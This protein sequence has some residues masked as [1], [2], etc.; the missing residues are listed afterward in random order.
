MKDQIFYCINELLKNIFIFV[1]NDPLLIKRYSFT[2]KQ[3]IDF[4]ISVRKLESIQDIYI[5]NSSILNLL[6]KKHAN[7]F[8][9]FL[10]KKIKENIYNIT[11][12]YNNL[13]IPYYGYNKF[14]EIYNKIFNSTY[15]VKN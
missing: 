13:L 14:N 15:F 6:S 4:K 3:T 1:Q 8:E 11:T 10:Q 2:V 7:D 12:I 9:I 5:Y